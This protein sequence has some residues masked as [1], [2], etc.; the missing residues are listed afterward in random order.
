MAQP[1]KPAR[2]LTRITSHRYP[3]NRD[4][5][6]FASHL[7]LTVSK[8]GIHPDDAVVET[9]E[10]EGT[11]PSGPTV[12]DEPTIRLNSGPQ[13]LEKPTQFEAGEKLGPYVVERFL[14]G[15]GFASVYEV[16]EAGPEQ[17]RAAG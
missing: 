2:P 10:E 8:Q 9:F 13:V 7:V 12:V 15:G 6:V 14:A 1:P 11:P 4:G 16:I 5:E 3:R 17:R